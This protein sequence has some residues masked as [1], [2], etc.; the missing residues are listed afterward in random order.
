MKLRD[1]VRSDLVFLDLEATDAQSA[2]ATVSR[3]LG[4][5]ANRDPGAIADALNE[6]EKLGSTSVG[7]GF[8]IPHCKFGD[9]DEVVVALGRF[10]EGVDFG[11]AKNHEPVEFFFVVLS[12]PDRPTQ[13]LQVLSQIARIL[14]KPKL[15]AEMLEAV[16]AD[17]V[18]GAIH[19]A[20][21]GEGL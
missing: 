1:A 16:D 12:P 14:T 18:V 4:A 6:R 7:N 15:R 19:R 13:H 5:A 20:V 2:I 21:E 8:A 9:V 17:A 3:E 11:G 10:V